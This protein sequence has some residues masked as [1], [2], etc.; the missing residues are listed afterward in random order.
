MREQQCLSV[1]S[2][3]ECFL[4]KCGQLLFVKSQTRL[5]LVHIWRRM[6][7][8]YFFMFHVEN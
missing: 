7:Y 2:Q 3:S 8:I 6:K 1:F 4:G 5:C